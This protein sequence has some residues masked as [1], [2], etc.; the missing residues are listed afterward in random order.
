MEFESVMNRR[1]IGERTCTVTYCGER[2]RVNLVIP[3]SFSIPIAILIDDGVCGTRTWSEVW[4]RFT[5]QIR[6]SDKHWTLVHHMIE[7]ADVFLTMY[8]IR[9]YHTH[10]CSSISCMSIFVYGI[11]ALILVRDTWVHI[12]STNDIAYLVELW[13]SQRSSANEACPRRW[14]QLVNP[15]CSFSIA[16]SNWSFSLWI[17]NWS[18]SSGILLND[19]IIGQTFTLYFD[20]ERFYSRSLELFLPSSYFDQQ[21]SLDKGESDGEIML[22]DRQMKNE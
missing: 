5:K 10:A 4:W 18:I 21:Y 9:D 13:L 8:R 14:T 19:M 2:F 20:S 1:T 3:R 17:N 16:T 12:A 7:Q 15:L 22:R 6:E 11:V